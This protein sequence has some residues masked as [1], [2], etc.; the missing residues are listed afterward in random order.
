MEDWQIAIVT[1]FDFP[2]FTTLVTHRRTLD[3]F[4]GIFGLLKEEL[5][6]YSTTFSSTWV[7]SPNFSGAD[8]AILSI[9]S[10]SISRFSLSFP[11]ASR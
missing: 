6:V 3:R 5:E 11:D 10:N 9:T 7:I 1:P 4:F 2:D 8:G